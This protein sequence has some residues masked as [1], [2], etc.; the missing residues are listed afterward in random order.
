MVKPNA[1]SAERH[2]APG[3][4]NKVVLH[5]FR[6]DG[7]ITENYRGESRANPDAYWLVADVWTHRHVLNLGDSSASVD[8]EWSDS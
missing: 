6:R 8:W 4:I 3:L 7:S 1:N 5:K 2:I